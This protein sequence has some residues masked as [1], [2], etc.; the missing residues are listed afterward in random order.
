ME[1]FLRFI[2]A[3]PDL[4]LDFVS[5][6]RKGTVQSD[7]PDPRRLH[8]AAVEVAELAIAIDAARFSGITIINNEA[9][10]KVGF[11][12][13]YR[14]RMDHTASSWLGAVAAIHASLNRT[15]HEA[16]V[17]FLAAA[18]NANLQLMEAP[19]DGRRSLVT[20]P[21]DDRTDLINLPV[22][23]FYELVRLMG[24]GQVPAAIGAERLFPATD[25]YHLCTASGTGVAALLSRY[26][27]SGEVAGDLRTV[28]YVVE[29][30]PWTQFNVAL[31]RIDATH[32]NAW[33][34]AA[35]SLANPYPFP[36]PELIPEIRQAQELA[37]SR[38]AWFG[39]MGTG[40]VWRE[41]LTVEPYT[42]VCLWITPY[43][44]AVPESP[45]WLA[46]DVGKDQTLLRWEPTRSPSFFSYEVFWLE[47]D[48]IG[49]RL[50]PY[51]LRA[52][53]WVD[54]QS[55]RDYGVRTVSASGIHGPIVR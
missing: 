8:Q 26:P 9:D 30:L 53:M 2:A 23:H 14:P 32:S 52:A 42:T 10:E 21:G 17:R 24:D 20:F 28:E 19:F 27:D 3:D 43:S 33:T 16:G 36:D 12:A 45:E 48:A 11:E 25:L 54:D 51:P 40:G 38:L 15:Y 29:G 39:V 6:H 55:G 50:S 46:V 5:F 31:F 34:A 37:L 4:K 44:D 47:G 49:E 7:P 22:Y 35:G 41:T 1:R 13:P 18:D